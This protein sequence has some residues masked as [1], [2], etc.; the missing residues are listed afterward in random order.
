MDVG[1]VAGVVGRR[2]REYRMETAI[3]KARS[4][5]VVDN[6]RAITIENES[7]VSSFQFV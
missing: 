5:S 2:L 1:A 4:L 6:D 7:D 3:L